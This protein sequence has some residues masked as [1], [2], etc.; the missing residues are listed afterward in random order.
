MHT[1]RLSRPIH[2]IKA[3]VKDFEEFPDAA[4]LTCL[5][6]LTVAAEGGMSDIAKPFRGI[7]PGIFE[8]ALAYRGEA[9]RVI[10]VV[11][12]ADALWVVHAFQK[13][14]HKGIKTPQH[15]IDLIGNRIKRLRRMLTESRK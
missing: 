4:Q 13:K 12:I 6:A 7:G 10:Y 15:E 9:Y 14:S 1:T 3:A 2:W 11:Q 5:R 8:I